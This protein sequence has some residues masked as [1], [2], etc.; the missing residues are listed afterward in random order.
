VTTGKIPRFADLL[1]A[2]SRDLGESLAPQA[3]QD[4]RDLDKVARGSSKVIGV[5]DM[6]SGSTCRSVGLLTGRVLL[7]GTSRTLV[8]GD[9]TNGYPCLSV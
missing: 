9:R 2:S 4:L 5:A 7:T 3:L 1:A 6:V 8:S